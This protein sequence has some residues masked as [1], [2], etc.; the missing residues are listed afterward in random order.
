LTTSDWSHSPADAEDKRTQCQQQNISSDK[1]FHEPCALKNLFKG[2]PTFQ[3]VSD[4]RL[5]IAATTNVATP[6]TAPSV[7]AAAQ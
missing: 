5:G 3:T 6:Q 7:T 4:T 1:R 2:L